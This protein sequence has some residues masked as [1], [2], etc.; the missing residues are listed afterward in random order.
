MPDETRINYAKAFIELNSGYDPTD[1]LKANIRDFCQDKLPDYQI[2]DV[3]EFTDALPRTDR[4]KVDYRAL[5]EMA[6]KD[7][8]YA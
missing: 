7:T 2:P 4:G 3:I 6:K 1:K 5:E 8:H